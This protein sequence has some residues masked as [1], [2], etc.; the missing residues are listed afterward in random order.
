VLV[1]RKGDEV[2]VTKNGE[3]VLVT[4]YGKRRVFLLSPFFV[5]SFRHPFSSPLSNFQPMIHAP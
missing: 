3:E 5:T 1:T 2:R 4:K